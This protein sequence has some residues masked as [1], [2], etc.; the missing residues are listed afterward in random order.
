[1]DLRQTI[2]LK[3]GKKLAKSLNNDGYIMKAFTLKC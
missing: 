2:V 1:M 3:E